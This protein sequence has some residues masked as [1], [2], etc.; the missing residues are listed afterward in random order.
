MRFYLEGKE[1]IM[2]VAGIGLEQ[3]YFSVLLSQQ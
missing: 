1:L 3:E 2:E